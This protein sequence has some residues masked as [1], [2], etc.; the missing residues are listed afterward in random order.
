M[1][2]E[3]RMI[4]AE[5]DCTKGPSDKQVEFARQVLRADYYSSIRSYAEEIVD[6]LKKGELD[7]SEAVTDYI[8][9]TADGS[10][11]VIYTGRNY[12][13]LFASDHDPSEDLE[14]TESTFKPEV[15]AFFCV[16]ADLDSQVI[17][18]LGQSVD[19]WLT[20]KEEAEEA[21][22]EAAAEEASDKG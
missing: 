11:W 21:A 3:T 15:A 4:E 9:E 19:D 5:W 22:K 12:Q 20:E 8:H 13:V 1:A 18:E 6:M 2:T 16:R 17:S 14:E 10:E 7:S